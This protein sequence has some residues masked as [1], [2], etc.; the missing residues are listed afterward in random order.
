M[1][2]R[3]SSIL[4]I[5]L[6]L[7]LFSCGTGDGKEKQTGQA[8]DPAT[9][10]GTQTEPAESRDED[11]F[12]DGDLRDVT[13]ETPNAVITLSG[14]T[15]EISDTTRGSS[16][17]NVTIRSK[18]IYRIKGS[19]EDVSIIIDDGNKSG[20]VYL[21]FEEATMINSSYP[22][23]VVDNAD[24]VVLLSDGVSS[25]EY[26]ATD[27]E[28]DGAVYSSDDVTFGGRGTLEI[29]SSLPGV[30][31]KDDVKVTG[32]SIRIKSGKI[33]INANDSLKIGGGSLEINAGKEGIRVSDDVNDEL[34]VI[35]DGSVYIESEKD[36]IHSDHDALFR[37]GK[38]TIISNDDAVHADGDL[39]VEAGTVE[40]NRSYEGI[41]AGNVKVTGGETSVNSSDDGINASD[42]SVTV[43]GGKVYVNAG[44]D[45]IDANGSIFVSGGDVIIEGPTDD[46]NGIL[47]I[48]KSGCVAE[49]TGGTVLAIGSSGMAINFDSGTQCSALVS[50]S[51]NEGAE[52]TVDDG[53][54]FSFTATKQFACVL[55]SS[56]Y[57]TKGNAYVITAG[58]ATAKADFS[59][60]MFYTDLNK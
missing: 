60:G 25:L 43:S 50:L 46:G 20:V 36:G 53:S 57:L 41:E 29:G 58:T 45:G 9:G 32:G 1:K 12:S 23:V 51:G 3:I 42:G 34:F 59:E 22:C 18:G 16:G 33:G 30:V 55:Y 38:A 28:Y 14:K 47:D 52:I 44:G 24:K 39:T 4:V 11:Y 56:P 31:G 5:L 37:G 40:I 35:L 48:T 49:I 54:G 2:K 6:I 7:S 15:G 19:S 8:T 21:V 26:T 27:T 17:D 10:S 13:D